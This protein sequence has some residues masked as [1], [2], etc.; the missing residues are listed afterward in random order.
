MFILVTSSFSEVTIEVD[1]KNIIK[2]D[3]LNIIIK[4]KSRN[5]IFPN[6]N[7]IGDYEIQSLFNSEKILQNN[8]KIIIE[9][10][11]S[12]TIRPDQNFT[13]PPLEVKIDGKIQKTKPLNI[14]VLEDKALEENFILELNTPNKIYQNY[15]NLITIKFMQKTNQD[16][17]AL[18]LNMPKGNFELNPVSKEKDYFEGVYKVYE[19]SYEFI[20]KTAGEV[21]LSTSIKIGKDYILNQFGFTTKSIK[22]K[23]LKTEKKVQVLPTPNNIVGEYK[24]SLDLDKQIVDENEP[25]NATLIIEGNGYLNNI[26]D[27][28]LKIPNVT[29]YDEKPVIKK[30]LTNGKIYSRYE[31]KYVLLSNKNYTIEPINF[32]FYS[33]NDNKLKTVSTNKFEIQIKSAPIKE[34][35]KEVIKEEKVYVTNYFLSIALFI[36]GMFLGVLLAL[37]IQRLKKVS[38]IS[39]PDNL[40]KKLL[41]FAD[42]K[43]VLNILYKLENKEPLLKEEKEY[44]KTLFN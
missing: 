15:S 20:P 42:D 35:I 38:N 4:S 43:K 17:A 27:V 34:V 31:K 39:L 28:K 14:T 36:L 21:D 12:Y 18:S 30:S 1:K 29:V 41:P 23:T 10:S 33:I 22:Y 6:I 24:I 37:Y 9:K 40:Y 7:K 26:E 16:V 11:I 25:I 2:G 19:M 3:L 32:S 44:I 5:V 8:G 13:I